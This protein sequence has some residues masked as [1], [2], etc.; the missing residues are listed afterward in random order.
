[1]CGAPLGTPRPDAASAAGLAVKLTE[2]GWTAEA[3]A[4]MPREAHHPF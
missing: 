3:V 4:Q 2:L 1:M